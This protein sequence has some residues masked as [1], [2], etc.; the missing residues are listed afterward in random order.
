MHL[1]KVFMTT[2]EMAHDASHRDFRREMD[3]GKEKKRENGN[4]G[5]L[6]GKGTGKGMGIE[7]SSRF[8]VNFPFFFTQ[9]LL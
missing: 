8:P 1:D 6:T 3:P 5:R 2:L 4:W 7:P 9:S